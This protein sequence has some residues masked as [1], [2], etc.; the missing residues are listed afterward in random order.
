[1]LLFV[2]LKN[3]E[4]VRKETMNMRRE[5]NRLAMLETLP[6]GVS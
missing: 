3:R 6:K 4:K 1:L 5:L 2:I